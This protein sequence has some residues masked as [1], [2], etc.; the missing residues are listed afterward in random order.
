MAGTA[1]TDELYGGILG[2]QGPRERARLAVLTAAFDP[3]T[4]RRLDDLRIGPDWSCLEVGA[5]SGSIAHWLA[6]RVPRGRVVATDLDP[7]LLQRPYPVNMTVRR[8]DVT[9]EEFPAGS[10]RLIHARTV[11]M[12]LPEREHTVQRMLGWLEPGGI[13]LVEEL[14]HFPRH[15][16]PP[17][18]PFR[19]AVEAWWTLLSRTFGMDATWGTRV[20][21]VM[22]QA[23]YDSIH[24]DADLPALRPGTAIADFSRLTLEALEERLVNDGYL[25]ADE[26][27]A[28]YQEITHPEHISF[29][30]A[31]IATHGHRPS[32]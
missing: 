8:H 5:G 20:A 24:V 3:G 7:S 12:H 16:M 11:L 32:R 2:H 21:T 1:K 31:V 18:S 22:R 10:F 6:E 19:R 29:P 30:M 26:I 4:K 28:A 15:G 23:G 13:L 27:R 17:S 9:R 14:A 25:T